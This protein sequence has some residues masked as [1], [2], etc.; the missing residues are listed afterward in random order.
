MADPTHAD[1]MRAIG[2]LEGKVDALI[3][4]TVDHNKEVAEIHRRID[5]LDEKINANTTTGVK[6]WAAILL[7]SGGVST[8]AQWLY[9]AISGGS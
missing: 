2:T 5:K 3:R 8:G 4:Q 6:L 7:V 9:K 1:L